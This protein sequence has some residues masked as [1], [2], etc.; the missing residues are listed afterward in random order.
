MRLLTEPSYVEEF[1]ILVDEVTDQYVA[2]ELEGEDRERVE[3]YF[4]KSADRRQKLR[5]TQAL[6][7]YG[8]GERA[9]APS[10]TNPFTTYLAIAATILVMVGAGFV[11]WRLFFYQSDLNKGLIA[12]R[13]A[14]SKERPLEARLSDFSYAPVANQRGGPATIDYVQRDLAANLLLKEVSEHPSAASHHA[15]GQYYL[16]ERKLDQAIDQFQKALALAPNNAKIHSDLGAAL[17]EKGK[18][19]LDSLQGKGIQAFAES[20]KH[21]NKTLD[22]DTKNLEALFNRALLYDQMGLPLQAETDWRR[23]LELDPNSRWA[24]EARQN[25]KL[26]EEKIK[27]SS[28][29]SEGV[30]QEFLESYQA[31][32]DEASWK[33]LSG[34]HNRT[35]NVVIEHLLD[36][37]FEH[38]A[39][40]RVDEVGRNLQMLS[41]A[42]RLVKQRTGDGF[43]SDLSS[44][45]EL[46][47]GKQREMLSQAR[48]LMKQGHRGWGQNSDDENIKLFVKAK[49]LF[50]KAGARGESHVADY[51]IAFSFYRRHNNNESLS[52]LEP[53]ISKSKG[54]SFRQL[55]TR[56][57]YLL[58]A[59][60]FNRN[61]HSKALERAKQSLHLADQ[62]NDTVGMINALTSL[63]EYFR[64]LGNYDD[65]LSYI[66]RGLPLA[67]SISMDPIQGSRHFAFEATAFAAAGLPDAAREFQKEALRYALIT[68]NSS[69]ISYNYAFLGMINGKLGNFDEALK[70]TQ[71]AYEV[72]RDH[73]N[74]ASD[75]ELM[76]YAL[77]QTGHIYRQTRDFDNAIASYTG[78]I[79]GYENLN[80]PTTLYQAYKGRFL[81]YVAQQKDSLAKADLATTLKLA[82]EYRD[83]ILEETVSQT[84]FDREQ[85]LYDAAIDF[86]YSRLKDAQESFEI[87][88]L[89]RARSLLDLIHS[90]A[91][92]LTKSHE[93]EIITASV[94]SPLAAHK[95]ISQLP[96]KTQILQ[97]A[98]VEN[99]VVIWVV[100]KEKIS[101][102]ASEVSEKELIDKVLAYLNLA[103]S[104]SASNGDE[105]I[106]QAKSLYQI[107]I[108]PI[109]SQLD[110]HNQI[111]IVPDKVLNYLPF[112]ALVS[113]STG[114]Y[115]LEDYRLIVSPSSTVFIASSQI[116]SEKKLTGE[117]KLLS[118]GNPRFN[119]RAF[120]SFPDLPSAADEA[121]QVADYYESPK[122]LIGEQ[123]KVERVKLEIG[124][125]DVVHLAL[126]SAL[127]ERF[128][129]RS[130]LLLA[131]DRLE[132]NAESTDGVLFAYEIYGLKLSR[133]RLAVLSA[134]ET[135]AEKYSGGEGMISLARPFIAARVP[136]VVASLWPVDS[137]FTQQLMVNF[138][139][140][141]K[142]ESLSTIDALRNAQIAMLNSPDARH[143]RPYYW[144]PFVLIGGH[145]DF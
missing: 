29:S 121:R 74:E 100:S 72:A 81:C 59:V 144:A 80:H 43:F 87:S 141:R 12:L 105:L 52:I 41:Y 63:I 11:A 122:F 107:L 28:K 69:V 145:A 6:K 40:G 95:V 78:S 51:W 118:V 89:S 37:Y 4:L 113:P 84:F 136:L 142:I 55:L 60:H 42:A 106:R 70:A 8:K 44:F 20:L 101:A 140:L 33:V 50:D 92:V 5:F 47:N 24:E 124:E 99:R 83:K 75:R 125:A 119:R 129:L 126:H 13:S 18:S 53:L 62:I 110:P 46:I 15:L 98:V 17:M 14:F 2:G 131:S 65:S 9:H 115:L 57:L 23:Y 7:E 90:D 68:G 137:Y 135:G 109:E 32:N 16:A 120:P 127:D 71:L 34:Y 54:S 133:T 38:N 67:S 49:E 139:R 10:K 79:N 94:S 86:A 103:S 56:C 22:L 114:K 93:P 35:G 134:C 61:E 143:R 31:R 36:A 123:A 132:Q 77:L 138:Q 76:A 128:P 130:K 19:Q 104:P 3:K 64:Y 111:C 85:S 116:A 117:E 88:E 91:V 27:N 1:D 21:F 25:L 108:Q 73:S 66:Q 30:F 39:K 112:A 97:Y 45:Y 48:A 58:A 26:V 82:E 102:V 96:E